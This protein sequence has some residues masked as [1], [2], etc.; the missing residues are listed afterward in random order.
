MAAYREVRKTN[1][2]LIFS[3]IYT[4]L[5]A[6]HGVQTQVGPPGHQMP[7][8]MSDPHL[9][10]SVD[11]VV[12][13]IN[14][15]R[16]FAE[17][18][19][20]QICQTIE[21]GTMQVVDGE[22][23]R[24]RLI[25][26]DSVC[27]NAEAN[28]N[29]TSSDCP[30][31]S[32]GKR[33]RC[34]T[35]VLYNTWEDP[36]IDV[37]SY[38]CEDIQPTPPGEEMPI[39]K[40]DPGVA[41]SVHAVVIKV[42]N[43]R[44]YA[45]MI[46]R[47]SSGGKTEGTVQITDGNV[48]RLQFTIGDSVCNN[49]I[50]NWNASSTDCPLLRPEMKQR[51]C[52]ATVIYKHWELP[53]V[54][55]TEYSCESPPPGDQRPISKNSTDVIQS[56]EAAISI[57]NYDRGYSNDTFRRILYSIEGG[58]V[59]VTD[60]ELFRLLFTIADSDC[61]NIE[62]NFNATSAVCPIPSSRL[63][64]QRCESEV[65]DRNW[66]PNRWLIQ[67]YKCFNIPPP[68]LPPSPSS[69]RPINKD[70]PGVIASVD[71]AVNKINEVRGYADIITRESL[72]EV[73][74]GTV[75][76]MV[77][78]GHIYRLNFT[79]GNSLCNNSIYNANA[80]SKDCPL[81]RTDH[82]LHSCNTS[83]IYLNR[84]TT[85]TIAIISYYCEAPPGD[86]RLINKSD[87]VVAEAADEAVNVINWDRGYSDNIRRLTL[88]Q[89]EAGTVKI[90]SGE[91]YKLI[92]TLSNSV[93][94]NTEDNANATEKQCPA[95]P[96][97]Q[98]LPVQ[99]CESQI[100]YK[101]WLPQKADVMEHSCVILPP[102]TVPPGG[103]KEIN[104]SDPGVTESVNTAIEVINQ[105]R[106]YADIIIRQTLGEL[107][108][109]TV[110]V[111]DGE[112]YRLDFTIGNSE[113]NNSIVNINATPAEC[114]L[115]PGM[116]QRECN[117]TVIYK[118]WETPRSTVLSHF[119]EG[120]SPGDQVIINRTDPGVSFSINSAIAAINKNRGYSNN[121]SRWSLYKLEGGTEQIVDGSVYRL[122]FTL[123]N[124][125]C[126]NT[127]ANGNATSSE[128]PVKSGEQG[129][130]I[131]R[132]DTKTIYRRWLDN[133][134]D[135]IEH[136]CNPLP[137][138][139]P[140]PR[141]GDIPYNKDDPLVMTV[142]NSV[143]DFINEARGYSDYIPRKSLSEILNG[144]YQ[145]VDG[146]LYHLNFI[147]GISI[148]NNSKDNA[149]KTTKDCPLRPDS[150]LRPT[151][152]MALVV[153]KSWEYSTQVIN[154]TCEKSLYVRN[155]N[156]LSVQSAHIKMS[157]DYAANEINRLNGYSCCTYRYVVS[158]IINPTSTF[159][160]TDESLHMTLNLG[161]SFCT[162]NEL[163]KDRTVDSCPIQPG[164]SI[165]TCDATVLIHNGN[166]L[167][168]GQYRCH[169]GDMATASPLVG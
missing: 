99:R 127:E 108:D 136:D 40:S 27:T 123:S 144:T 33:K 67:K 59:Q 77:D 169:G 100:Y 3:S 110:Q 158:D 71:A 133:Q 115:I 104:R 37:L 31:L 23:F 80:T 60:G 2:C 49:S 135:V 168:M 109:G 134:T 85:T 82:G 11:A 64:V 36:G 20:R 117:A 105:E 53:L 165:T 73:V 118:H 69:V 166:D 48:Y 147:I 97:L 62:K 61:K 132:C 79:I 55:V 70:D 44:G 63:P 51:N 107:V 43:K 121:T 164:I 150:R 89:V 35:A 140:G 5:F 122:A 146:E 149:N 155:D 57:I 92:F 17:N 7:I 87:P 25:L 111:V 88:Y 112:L 50:V 84:E 145:I 142:T 152:C 29:K 18:L 15:D 141:G 56:A 128:C 46:T 83:V 41:M 14:R 156:D 120:P 153:Y 42:N 95:E 93:C 16:G 143:V 114:P 10:A 160:G 34:Q 38:D 22:L 106:G 21:N 167:S 138:P 24:L 137:P 8:N 94:K 139:P 28:E 72:G 68:P 148:C 74:D 130:P 102:P 91:M 125:V 161:K 151:E 58:T 90:V 124:S 9:H 47:V 26:A 126:P 30:V 81:I 1:I 129:L 119:C 6:V 52:N 32:P 78:E 39:N 154:W 65:L 12:D 98:G 162:N 96:G 163:N 101:H 157:G 159:T 116:K 19:Q 13:V 66:L 86:E 76:D 4:I 113:C 131:Q 45:D 75:E 103:A 54:N